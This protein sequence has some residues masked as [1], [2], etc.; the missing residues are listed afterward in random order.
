MAKHPLESA[1]RPISPLQ[2]VVIERVNPTHTD[3]RRTIVEF[4]ND[5]EMPFR[6]MKVIRINTP[7]GPEGFR[8]GQHYHEDRELFFLDKGDIDTLVLEDPNTKERQVHRNLGVNTRI[9]LPANVAHLF[10][11]TGPATLLAFSENPFNPANLVPYQIE[12]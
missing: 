2:G 5:G 4:Q 3:N 12:H 9:L 1:A 10:I 11:F 6:N 7:E 8:L